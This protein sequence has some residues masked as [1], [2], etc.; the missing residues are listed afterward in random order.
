MCPVT[1]LVRFMLIVYWSC[2]ANGVISI[3]KLAPLFPGSGLSLRLNFA[4]ELSPIN[5]SNSSLRSC[6]GVTIL[7]G[8]RRLSLTL[9]EIKLKSVKASTSL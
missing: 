9:G 7:A 6:S 4:N 2:G 5:E 3:P 1:Q 8:D